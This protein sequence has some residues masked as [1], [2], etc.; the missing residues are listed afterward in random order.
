MASHHECLLPA[1]PE[2]ILHQK[3]DITGLIKPQGWQAPQSSVAK[4]DQLLDVLWT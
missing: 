4:P 3:V 1:P 2:V